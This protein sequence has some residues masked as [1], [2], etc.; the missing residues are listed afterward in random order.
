M[1]FICWNSSQIAQTNTR[2]SSCVLGNKGIF[3]IQWTTTQFGSNQWNY[4]TLFSE[5]QW[6]LHMKYTHRT[7]QSLQYYTFILHYRLVY[8]SKI[9]YWFQYS[10]FGIQKFS[11]KPFSCHQPVEAECWLMLDS[12]LMDVGGV[13]TLLGVV[14][15]QSMSVEDQY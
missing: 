6:R 10:C 9:W 7:S 12:P 15:L 8:I 3:E 13:L 14:V 5:V 2:H 11:E 1:L 4:R